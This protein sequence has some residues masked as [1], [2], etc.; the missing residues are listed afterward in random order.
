MKR[1]PHPDAE[2]ACL[3]ISRRGTALMAVRYSWQTPLRNVCDTGAPPAPQAS[4]R[5]LHIFEIAGLVV[6]ADAGRGDP[7]RELAGLD[8]LFHQPL[9]EL[10]IGGRGQP[11]VLVL[12]PRRLVDDVAIGIGLDVAEFADLPMERNI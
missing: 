1:L 5:D 9:D 12:V 6:D 3:V 10:A 8:H 11:L 4:S 7:A 2:S